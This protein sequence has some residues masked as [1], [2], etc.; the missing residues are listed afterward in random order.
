MTLSG[1]CFGYPCSSHKVKTVYQ[2]ELRDLSLTHAM[3]MGKFHNIVC[4]SMYYFVIIIIIN[5]III[6][7]TTIIIINYHH[8]HCFNGN[9]TI[10]INSNDNFKSVTSIS[11]SNLEKVN[12]CK[13]LVQE[14]EL[15]FIVFFPLLLTHFAFPAF[16]LLSFLLKKSIN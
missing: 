8:Q 13:T 7:T 2:P 15:L 3:E 12:A 11:S 10:N 9:I 14:M 16:L 1:T 6:M 5:I 4:I